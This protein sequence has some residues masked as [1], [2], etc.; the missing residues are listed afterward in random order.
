[1]IDFL[2]LLN[3]A[4]LIAGCVVDIYTGI[5]VIAPLIIPLGELFGIHPV[6]L[7]IIFLANFEIGYLTPPVGLNLFLASYLFEKPLGTTYRNALPFFL[8]LLLTVLL[9]TYVPWFSTAL[10]PG[11]TVTYDENLADEG[12]VPVTVRRYKAGTAVKVLGNTG[13]LQRDG[14]S[15][16]GWSTVPDGSGTTY[17]AGDRF[18][19][20]SKTIIL[21]AKWK[22]NP[23]QSRIDGRRYYQAA[24]RQRAA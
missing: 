18:T 8:A 21:Y 17:R 4:L 15:F 7:G 24:Q 3:M 14:Y 11:D 1:M 12:A 16:V 23:A 5:V 19:M 22:P 6:H 2:I 20:Q 9:I 13:S 10:L